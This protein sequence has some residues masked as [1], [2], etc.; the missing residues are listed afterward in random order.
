MAAWRGGKRVGAWQAASAPSADAPSGRGRR[1]P[2]GSGQRKA[3][4]ATRPPA[5]KIAVHG[6]SRASGKFLQYTGRPKFLDSV[7]DIYYVV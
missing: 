7:R 1:G 3:H 5:K 6:R 2:A 4:R